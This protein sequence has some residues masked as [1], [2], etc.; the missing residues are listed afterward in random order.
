[1]NDAFAR[2]RAVAE[3]AADSTRFLIIG[4]HVGTCLQLHDARLLGVIGGLL[5]AALA[6]LDLRVMEGEFAGVADL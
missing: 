2:C 5:L 3:T 6:G 4:R 1:M